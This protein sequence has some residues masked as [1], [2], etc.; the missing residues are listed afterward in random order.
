[1]I[2]QP[3]TDPPP[4]DIRPRSKRERLSYLEGWVA[5]AQYALEHPSD[6]TASLAGTMDTERLALWRELFE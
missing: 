3:P 6:Q 5:G 4:I 2:T 1:M